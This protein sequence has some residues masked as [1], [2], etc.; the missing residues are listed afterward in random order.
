MFAF[1]QRKRPRGQMVVLFVLAIVGLVGIA[2]LAVDGGRLALE[3]RHAQSAADAASMA[4]G[5]VISY[6]PA[7][8]GGHISNAKLQEAIAAALHRAADNGY[9]NDGT[10]NQVTVNI[11]GPQRENLQWVYYVNVD[12]T[13][14]IPPALIQVV[15]HG[16]LK[17]SSHAQVRARPF[18]PVAWGYTMVT[19]GHDTPGLKISGTAFVDAGVSGNIWVNSSTKINGTLTLRVNDLQS[20]GAIDTVGS[21]HVEGSLSS[22]LGTPVVPPQIPLPTCSGPSRSAHSGTLQPG[23]YSSG[24][25]ING[26]TVTFRPGIYC[27]DNGLTISN[28]TVTGDGVL[29]FVRSGA[30]KITGG[31]V[32][33]TASSNLTDANGNQWAGMLLYMA[34][35]NHSGLTITGNENFMLD[36]TVYVPGD[37]S[38]VA[39]KVA[40][41]SGTSTVLNAQFICYSAEIDGTADLQLN[42]PSAT[43]DIP[44]VLDMTQ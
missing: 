20:V 3:K 36:G 17:A 27:V 21:P 30:V 34:P 42:Y 39:C 25:R 31:A 38:P 11:T 32:H 2:G 5:L 23:T 7:L 44:P 6:A 28:G 4:G 40:G 24:I 43:Y 29:F 14:A 10:H 37:A 22:S 19:T 16:P 1:P 12:I 13:S 26:G 9:G 35:D 18:Q 15:Y 41:T 33:L 8:A